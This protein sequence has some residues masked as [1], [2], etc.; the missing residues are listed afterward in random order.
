[1]ELPSTRLIRRKPDN[2]PQEIKANWGAAAAPG[3]LHLLA[4]GV[5]LGVAGVL[6]T[7]LFAKLLNPDPEE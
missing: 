3:G 5:F 1:M 7:A 4:V 2:G 6:V